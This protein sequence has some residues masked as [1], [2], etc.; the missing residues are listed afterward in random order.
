MSMDNK[1]V[2]VVTNHHRFPRRKA[3]ML[4]TCLCVL[5]LCASLALGA[6]G[7]IQKAH[8]ASSSFSQGASSASSSQALFWFQ[9]TGWTAGYVILHYLQPGAAQQNVNMAYNSGTARWE[10]T[11]GGMSSGQVITYSFTYQQSGLQ[12]DTGNYTFTFGPSATPTPTPTRGTTPTPTPTS[13]ITPTPTT[14]GAAG[15]FPLTLQNNTR[16]TWS[17]SQIYITVLGQ[18]AP[19]Q[20]SYMKLDGTPTHINHLDANAPNH[21][22]KNGVNYANMSFTLAQASTITMPT[23]LLGA[24]MYISLG[25]PMYIPIASD[26]SGWGGPDLQNPNDPNANTYFDWYEF[27]YQYGVTAFGG[28][29]TQVDQFSFPMTARLQQSSS[30]FD[31]TNGITLT[32]AQVF[33][34]YAAAVSAAFQPLSTT[35][36]IIAPRSSSLFASGGS[37]ANYMQAYIDQTWNYYTNNQFT[38][39]R[40]GVTF[41]GRVVNGQLQ[42]TRNGVGPFVLNKPSTIDVMQCAGPLA[43]AGMTSQELELGAEFCAAFNRGVALN[44]A[45]WYT[46]STYY[47]GSIKNDYAMVWHQVSINN[48]AYGFAYDDVN[49]QSSVAILPNANPPSHLTIGIGW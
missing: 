39:T 9:P 32:R 42:F 34:Q 11:A 7:E 6:L 29:T 13:G 16:G 38:L 31:Q 17:N 49:N 30:G 37:Q 12:Y 36:R 33:S 23:H 44:T 43:S 45:N 15:T 24:R 27:A 47:T 8:A 5:V 2:H 21:L 48:K 25:S 10:Y 40:G 1:D 22:T 18:A 35:Y 28:N 19:G 26:D 3:V 41:T 14:V 20:W 4:I 46:P